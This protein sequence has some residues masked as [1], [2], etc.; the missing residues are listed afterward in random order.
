MTERFLIS[1]GG[2]GGHIFPALAI[3]EEIRSRNPNAEILFVGA[4]GGM[5]TRL[6]PDAGFEIRTVPVA[7]IQ[8]SFSWRAIKKNLSFPFK[9]FRSLNEA[10][11]IVREFKPSHAVGTGGY[12]SFPALKV[13]ASASNVRTVVCEQNAFPGLANRRLAPL[14]DAVCLGNEDARGYFKA[15]ALHYTGNPVRRAIGSGDRSRGLAFY[16]FSQERPVVVLTGGS[17]G[18]RSLNAAIENGLEQLSQSPVQLL[19]QCGKRYFDDLN[20]RL[21]LPE[22]IRLAPFIEHMED[23]YAMAD[24]VVCRAGALTLSELIH[25]SMP[26]ILSPSPNVAEDHQTQN[27][28]SLTRRNAAIMIKDENLEKTLAPKIIELAEKPDQLAVLKAAME[29]IEKP[30]ARNLICDIIYGG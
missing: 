13:A 3:A 29:S 17:L 14:V 4:E 16:R 27:A 15:K 8:R 28:L 2:T 1:G 20:D 24:F 18:A 6:V 9:Y 25:V 10:K 11:R 12:A 7:G 30:D 22:N 19:W 5:E 23:A 26:A 21:K